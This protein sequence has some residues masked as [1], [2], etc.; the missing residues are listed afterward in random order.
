[1]KILILSPYKRYF[2][3]ET[4]RQLPSGGTEKS[5]AFLGEAF[6]RLG[7]EVQ[8]VTRL[9]DMEASVLFQPDVVIGQVANFFEVFPQAYK[10]WWTHNFSDQSI[11][12]GHINAARQYADQIITLSESHQQEFQANLNVE[13]T[14]IGHGVWL[15]EIHPHGEKIPHKL[16]YCSNPHRG[17]E[18]IPQIFQIIQGLCP[19]ATLSVCSS[20]QT[21]DRPEEDAQY[22]ALFETLS[23]MP[24]VIL[25]GSMNQN[26]LYQEMATASHFF[27]PC[28][29]GETYC[30]AMD[31]ALAHGCIPAVMEIGC[32]GSLSERVPTYSIDRLMEMIQMIVSPQPVVLPVTAPKD[33]MDIAREWEQKVL[34]KAVS[35]K[36][37]SQR[38][39]EN[40]QNLPR[41]NQVSSPA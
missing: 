13:S 14:V 7:H 15:N 39:I 16:L 28:K 23:A 34:Y 8:C 26:Q 10:V 41:M 35:Q 33:W 18:L 3:A 5:A 40:I 17:L 22:R 36:V 27:Y 25:H 29:F 30:I 19:S 31:E 11:I 4:V 2:D 12:K 24:G 1:M 9:E 37:A 32:R 38:L 6:T 21:Y 20:M